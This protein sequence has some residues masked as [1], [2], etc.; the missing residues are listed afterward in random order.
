MEPYRGPPRMEPYR[1]PPHVEPS[2]GPSFGAL[3]P[4]HGVL[5]WLT[6]RGACP[7]PTTRRSATE[8]PTPPST[9][10]PSRT[11]RQLA[12]PA[13][14]KPARTAS[15]SGEWEVV[16][17]SRAPGSNSELAGGGTYAMFSAGS[18]RRG[19]LYQGPARGG[20]KRCQ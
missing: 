7:W 11:L 5:P 1:G 4:V 12:R 3:P 8:K 13:P 19:G 20:L 10:G 17:K 9:D 14:A 15:G 2:R 6:T 16:D 18:V